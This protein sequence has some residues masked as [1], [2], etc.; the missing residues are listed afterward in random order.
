MENQEI[1]QKI[2]KNKTDKSQT[3]V[4]KLFTYALHFLYSKLF[5]SVFSHIQTRIT[6]NKDTFYAVYRKFCRDYTDFA[7]SK[8]KNI[9][10]FILLANYNWK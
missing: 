9:S 10:Q 8:L 1:P 6:L 7:R 4:E 3:L 5:W 2:N